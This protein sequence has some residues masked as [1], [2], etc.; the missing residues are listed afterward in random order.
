VEVGR[1][2]SMAN[3][4]GLWNPDYAGHMALPLRIARRATVRCRTEARG[5]RYGRATHA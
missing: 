5:A 4:A 3:T 1:V 2:G